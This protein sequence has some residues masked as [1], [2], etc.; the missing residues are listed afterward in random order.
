MINCPIFLENSHRFNDDPEWGDIMKR[1]RTGALTDNDK[2]LINEHFVG[3]CDGFTSDPAAAVACKT[4]KERNAVEFMA[5]KNHL[6]A[7]HPKTNCNDAPPDNIL[8]VECSIAQ[9][10][11]RASRV[12]HDICHANLGDDDI[13]ATN[14]TC[15][16]AKVSPVLRFYPGSLHMANTNEEL[17]TKKVGNGSQCKC[18]SIKLKEGTTRKKRCN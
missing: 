11:K 2:T 15:K 10:N 17:K 1:M 16:G 12:I 14:L 5:W 6:I 8:F 13:K 7:K 4:N 3:R 9:K 18:K